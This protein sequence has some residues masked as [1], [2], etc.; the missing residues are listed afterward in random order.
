VKRAAAAVALLALS[1]DAA[2]HLRFPTVRAERWI[3]LRLDESPIR[4][5]YRVGFGT[6]LA[7]A[8]RRA[9]DRDSDG[10][11][12]VVEGNAALDDKTAELLSRVRVCVGRTLSEVECRPLSRRDV[13]Q[14]EAEGWVPGPSGHLHFAWTLRLASDAADL[15]ALRFEDAWEVAG[16]EIT[17]VR[18][19]PPRGAALTRAGEGD[20]PND[21]ASGFTWIEARRGAGPRVVAAAWPPQ[22]HP[23][24]PLL[25]LAL[26]STLIGIVAWLRARRKPAPPAG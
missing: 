24:W 3:E 5:G 9:A 22:A 21:V 13:E 4:I 26:A 20:E 14:V 8:A 12:S 7:K 2:A 17:D 11:V 19:K 1:T 15:G 10:E 25:G 16:V 23:S 6:E 18:I